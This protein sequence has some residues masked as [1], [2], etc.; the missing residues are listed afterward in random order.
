MRQPRKTTPKPKFQERT[1]GFDVFAALQRIEKEREPVDCWVG[2]CPRV[3]A[4]P[5][6]TP[7]CSSHGKPLCCEHYKQLHFVE[8]GRTP[9]HTE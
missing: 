5:A 1:K 8:T 6:H 4:K 7:C 3:T 9:C 2:R